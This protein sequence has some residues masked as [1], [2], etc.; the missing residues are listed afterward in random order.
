VFS[1][2]SYTRA[3]IENAGELLSDLSVVSNDP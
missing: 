3:K 2:V 1:S